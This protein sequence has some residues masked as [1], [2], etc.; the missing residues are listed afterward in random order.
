[1]KNNMFIC[2]LEDK[3]GKM[4]SLYK[5]TPSMKKLLPKND[6]LHKK[7]PKEWCM[8]FRYFF[9]YCIYE[10]YDDEMNSVA[11]CLLKNKQGFRQRFLDKDSVLIA[12]YFVKDTIRGRG[13]GSALV[14]SVLNYD[15][16]RTFYAF[17]VYDNIASRKAL[18][19]CKFE[20]VGYLKNKFK[21][22]QTISSDRSNVVVYKYNK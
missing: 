20:Q 12:P 7:F 19:N 4:F 9:G 17:V 13:V 6:I 1:M 14:K 3:R 22:I 21:V 8:L 15:N 16:H 11:F 5:F 2:N 18:E 10:L